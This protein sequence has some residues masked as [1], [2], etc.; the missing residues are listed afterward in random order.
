[1]KS[2]VSLLQSTTLKNRVQREQRRVGERASERR[3]SSPAHT[4]T[5]QWCW[6]VNRKKNKKTALGNHQT[7]A[8]TLKTSKIH[9]TRPSL[10][11]SF[12]VASCSLLLCTG[13]EYL[14]ETLQPKTCKEGLSVGTWYGM[15]TG[16]SS[17][18]GGTLSEADN[19][20]QVQWF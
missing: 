12:P 10:F 7:G 6:H 11:F 16:K 15:Q 19:D 8:T 1:M 14:S 18:C 20:F 13:S 5:S 2:A 4:N 17:H 3:E 9:Q